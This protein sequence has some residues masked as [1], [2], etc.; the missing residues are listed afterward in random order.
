MIEEKDLEKNEDKGN[1]QVKK[2]TDIWFAAYLQF[3][4]YALQDF[5]V[6]HPGKS[7]F[8]FDIPDQSWKD[9]KLEFKDN[10]IGV[11]NQIK[12][13]LFKSVVRKEGKTEGMGLSLLLVKKILD[14]YNAEIW[15]EDKVIGDPSKGSNFIILIPE[16]S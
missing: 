13:T 5:E 10:G 16:G 8:K 15:V 6:L 12:K 4:K 2:T 11:S 7:I 9:L 1:N 3:K 14:S